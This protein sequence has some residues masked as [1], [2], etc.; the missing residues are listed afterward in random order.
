MYN[1]QM[2]VRRLDPKPVSITGMGFRCQTEGELL[3]KIATKDQMP[4]LYHKYLTYYTFSINND[5]L[6]CNT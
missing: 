4:S 3:Q 2:D 5:Y 1:V 6:F